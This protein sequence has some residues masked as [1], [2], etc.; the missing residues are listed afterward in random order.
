MPP[1]A[2]A[3]DASV[4]REINIA[5]GERLAR[6][7]TAQGRTKKQVAARLGVT[8]QMYSK[9]EDGLTAIPYPRLLGIAES[10]GL[11]LAELTSA[12]P[13]AQVAR[14]RAERRRIADLCRVF[15]GLDHDA[16]GLLIGIAR[17]L[18]RKAR[19]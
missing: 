3:V 16:Q 17:E 18:R 12:E 19:P 1:R 14:D 8:Y 9:Y 11:S 10:F 4:E 13:T 7:R 5:F 6:I 15:E 2:K